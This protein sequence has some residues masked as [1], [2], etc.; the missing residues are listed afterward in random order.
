MTAWFSL[1][2]GVLKSS[3]FGS[4]FRGEANYKAGN[5]RRINMNNN[6]LVEITA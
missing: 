5:N 1:N 3:N 4:K 6:K 2:I